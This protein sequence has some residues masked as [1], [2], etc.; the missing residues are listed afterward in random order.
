VTVDQLADRLGLKLGYVVALVQELEHDG[1]VE[2]LENNGL[3]LTARAD[4]NYGQAL[5]ERK[6]AA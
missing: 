3:R 2:R 1:L 4:R 6:A 5:R